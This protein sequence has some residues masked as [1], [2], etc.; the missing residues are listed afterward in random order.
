VLTGFGRCLVAGAVAVT[1]T[2][3]PAAAAAGSSA[4]APAA[5]LT[6]AQASY[7]PAQ[8]IA[9][10]YTEGLGRIPDQSGWGSAVSYFAQNGCG[11]ASLAAYGQAVFTSAEYAGLGYGNA[12][13]LLTLYRGALNRE[14]DSSGFA[15]WLQHLS[16]GTSWPTAVQLFFTSPEFT[17]LVPKICSGVVDG[18]G[19]SYYFGTQPALALPAAGSGFTGSEAD[20]QSALNNA[21]AGG[22]TVS[23]AQQALVWLTKPLIIPPGVT[24][25][26]TGSPDLHHYADMARLVR[27]ATFPAP[28]APEGMVQVQHGAALSN[29]WVDGARH[30]P[31]NTASLENVMTYGTG[32]TVSSDRISETQG[33]S[34]LYLLGGYDGFPCT[35]ETVSGNLITAYS[36]DHYLSPDWA[37]GIT[38]NCEGATISGNQIVDATDVAIVVFRNTPDSG[39][40]SIVSGNYILSAG[41]SM[42]GG[43]GFDPLYNNTG[44]T[45]AQTLSFAGSAIKGNLLWTGPDTHFDIG[46]TDGSREWYARAGADPA[47]TGTGAS[48]TGNTTG[49]LSARVQTGVAV[50]GMLNTTVTGNTLT[51]SHITSGTCSKQNFVAEISAGYAT[52]TFSPA[53]ADANLDG[54]I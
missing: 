9:K 45:T 52:G 24:L 4:A 44:T 28:S 3:A 15:S 14:P 7:V 5:S 38:D 16:S 17:A 27:A 32:I 19:S 33:P 26:T 31:G 30:T 13:K 23:L 54:C 8:F 39:Q 48:I 11:A 34:S 53:P 29:V 20:L 2:I 49:T 21:A 12:A 42:Y 36:S 40:H 46:I 22:G 25:T 1:V 41:N 47:D 51:F 43:M 6:A 18:S 50:S 10:L 37:D 35:S